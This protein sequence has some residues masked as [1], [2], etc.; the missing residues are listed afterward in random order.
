MKE[1]DNF[2][3]QEAERGKSQSISFFF[4]FFATDVLLAVPNLI[5]VDVVKVK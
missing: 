2:K 3:A 1:S 5:A 4:F